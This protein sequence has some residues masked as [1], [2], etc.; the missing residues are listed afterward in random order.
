MIKTDGWWGVEEQWREED[1][2]E[3]RKGDGRE[4]KEGW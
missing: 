4:G 3:G 1:G 2:G